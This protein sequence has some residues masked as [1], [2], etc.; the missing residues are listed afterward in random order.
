MKHEKGNDLQFVSIGSKSASKRYKQ[1]EKGT[2]YDIETPIPTPDLQNAQKDMM[3]D[4]EKM[5]EDM[6]MLNID[7]D[8]DDI[9]GNKS[10]DLGGDFEDDEVQEIKRMKSGVDDFDDMHFAFDE[11][12]ADEYKEVVKNT[13]SENFNM[14]NKGVDNAR[15]D[16]EFKQNAYV[17]DIDVD[18]VEDVK[19]EEDDIKQRQGDRESF[20]ENDVDVNQVNQQGNEEKSLS[21]N[22]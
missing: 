18:K 21:T 10:S 22:T 3:K 5:N 13:E 12:V 15:N 6:D 20:D 4:E 8:I 1:K 9:C 2:Y 16:D 11:N 7:D 19:N 17:N 14:G